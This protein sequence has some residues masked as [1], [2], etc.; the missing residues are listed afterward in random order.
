[1]S[2]RAG[3]AVLLAV[4]VL[5]SATSAVGALDGETLTQVDIETDSTTLN[6]GVQPDGNA[7]WEIVYRIE[8]DDAN[9]TQA[10]DDLAQDIE[11]NPSTYLGPFRDRMERTVSAAENATGRQM[12]VRNVSI[13]TRRESQPQVTYGVL[14]YRFEWANFATQDG[15]GLAAGDAIDQFFLDSQ[16]A[17]RMTAPSGY[18]AVSVTPD[19]TRAGDG[20]V[21][22]EGQR[23]FDAGEPRVV[24]SQVTPTPTAG[25]GSAGSGGS[26]DGGAGGNGDT[27]EGGGFPVVVLLALAAFVVAGAVWVVARRNGD[28]TAGGEGGAAVTGDSGDS[29]DSGSDEGGVA[30]TDEPDGPPPELLSNEER[31]LQLLEQNGGR[32]KQKKVADDLDWTAAKTSQVVGDLRDEEKVESF[33]LGREN[34]LTLPDVEIEPSGADG[35]DES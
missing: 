12:T 34:V 11:A 10:F 5:V 35:D 1:M 25:D 9:T 16:T 22:W 27:G 7:T 18:S 2:K 19:P 28:D 17:L 4:V 32:M 30:A 24:F 26:G 15:D 6:V 14:V 21:V 20:E 23:D 3:L 13:D 33:R 31:V 8:L 29:G